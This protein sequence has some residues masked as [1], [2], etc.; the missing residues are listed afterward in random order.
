LQR[1]GILYTSDYVAN[2]GGLIDVAHDGP[3]HD[4]DAVRRMTEEIYDTAKRI[5]ARARAEDAP[6]SVIADRIAEERIAK[7]R[8]AEPADAELAA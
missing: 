4:A 6:T 1:R 2:A 5:F 8:E 3:G 7:S